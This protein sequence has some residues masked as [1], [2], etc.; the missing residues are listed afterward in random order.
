MVDEFVDKQPVAVFKPRQHAGAFYAYRLV[1]ECDD[2][3]GCSS[4]DDQIA[5]P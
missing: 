1:K 4:G 3:D 5:H 2:E